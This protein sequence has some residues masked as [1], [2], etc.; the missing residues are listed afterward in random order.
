MS[1]EQWQALAWLLAIAC[2]AFAF[3]AGKFRGL[4]LDWERTA[5]SRMD[6][7]MRLQNDLLGAH[8]QH[9]CPEQ[10]H[11]EY[12]SSTQVA[13]FQETQIRKLH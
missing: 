6:H 9:L 4:A 5:T 8:R 3:V 12:A 1:I 11:M 13:G 10:A 7:V 2:G